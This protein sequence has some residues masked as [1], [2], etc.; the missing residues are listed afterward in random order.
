VKP[1]PLSL[2]LCT[3]PGFFGSYTW[4]W[5]DGSNSATPYVTHPFQYY[6]FSNLGAY[7][8]RGAFVTHA[9]YQ[10]PAFV[11]FLQMSGIEKPDAA[12][13]TATLAAA[14]PGCSLLLTGVAP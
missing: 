12:C 5:A 11:R 3:K 1:L 4:P 2:Y 10:L 13:A 8:T 9:G 14:P 6:P 7:A